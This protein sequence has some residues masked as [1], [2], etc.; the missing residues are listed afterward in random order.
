VQ[1]LIDRLHPDVIVTWRPDGGYG[2][3]DHRLVSGAV[4]QVVQSRYSNIKLYY[5]GLS[6]AQAKPFN[7]IWPASL[8]FHTT[9]PAYLTVTV[10]YTPRDFEN[11]KRAFECHK[12]QF[13]PKMFR[14]KKAGRTSGG[15]PFAEGS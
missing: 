14:S 15:I 8:P 10:S 1:K 2:H 13:T 9:D 4:T 12:S 6:A 11:F 7:A 3:P 5:P